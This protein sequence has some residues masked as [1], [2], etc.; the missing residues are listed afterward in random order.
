MGRLTI[1]GGEISFYEPIYAKCSNKNAPKI[2]KQIDKN[3]P[4]Y[5]MV[6]YK[7]EDMTIRKIEDIYKKLAKLEDVLEKYDIESTEDLN[8][9]IHHKDCQI[10]KWKQ[11]YENCSKLEKFMSKQHQYCLDNWRACEQEL[12]KLKQTIPD[13]KEWKHLNKKIELNI[14]NKLMLENNKLEQEL[15]ELKQKV[16][17]PKFKIKQEIYVIDD[18]LKVTSA[19]IERVIIC[20]ENS[21]SEGETSYV[22][23]LANLG[24]KYEWDER[25]LI[26]NGEEIYL[27]KE[28]AGKKLAEI[29]GE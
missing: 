22:H 9:F 29:K 21:I 11:D 14:K 13:C 8:K 1:S 7:S 24:E 5:D 26:L 23:Y 25:Y 2:Q 27:T 10:N 15:A 4:F 18:Y 19:I 16:I 17:V 6:G 3:I 12:D 28:E 20:I